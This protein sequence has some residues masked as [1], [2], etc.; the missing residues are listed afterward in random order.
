MQRLV[1]FDLDGTL[2]NNPSSEKLYFLWLI[3][4]R[5]IGLKQIAYFLKFC[6]RWF[7]QMKFMVFVKNKAYLFGLPFEK[8]IAD[9]KGFTKTKLL[10][11][12]RPTIIKLLKKHQRNGDKIILLTGTPKFI[13]DVFAKKLGIREVE[14]TELQLDENGF[15]DLSPS[16]HPYGQEKL[17]IAK[18]ICK[19]FNFDLSNTVAYANSIH[20][21]SLLKSVGKAIA[22]TP[23]RKLRKIATKK[24]WDIVNI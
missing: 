12:L 2:I 19:K 5:K 16:Q 6:C 15:T 14:A 24:N 8:T 7:L 22:V 3:T 17:L 9:A 21:L 1:F 13:A 10:P 4:H 23:D 18:R 11:R 20:D